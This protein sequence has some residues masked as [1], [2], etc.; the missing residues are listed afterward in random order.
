MARLQA[1]VLE[2]AAPCIYIQVHVALECMDCETNPNPNPNPNPNQ[3]HTALAGLGDLTAVHEQP[4]AKR[5]G[6][7][8]KAGLTAIAAAQPA[9]SKL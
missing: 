4:L 5:M 6:P 2:A 7:A 1:Q 8:T 9:A 3:V